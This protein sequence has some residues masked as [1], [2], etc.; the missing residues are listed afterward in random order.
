MSNVQYHRS[1]SRQADAFRRTVRG[2]LVVLERLAAHAGVESDELD[3]LVDEFFNGRE[4]HEPYN[5]IQ[6]AGKE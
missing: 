6:D 5:P 2:I 1:S 3:Q 4:A